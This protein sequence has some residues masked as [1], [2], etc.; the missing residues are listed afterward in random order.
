[1]EKGAFLTFVR[2]HK[3]TV[4]LSLAGVAAVGGTLGIWAALHRGGG[5]SA[6]TEYARNVVLSKGELNQSVLV[7][8]TVESAQVSSVTTTLPYKVKSVN[9][10]VGDMVK[11]GDIICVLDDGELRRE[12]ADKQ[13]AAGGEVKTLQE[14]RDKAYRQLAAARTARGTEQAAQDQLV[15]NAR[16]VLAGAETE[17]QRTA[18]IYTAAQNAYDTMAAAVAP[19]QIAYDQ[20]AAE[21]Q[22][23]YGAWVQSGGGAGTAP[24]Q[25]YQQMLQQERQCAQ[26][27]EDAKTL[28]DYE[29]YAQA[30]QAA[31]APYDQAAASRQQA[32]EAYDQALATRT[33]TLGEQD[34]G[35]A[36]L[37]AAAGTATSQLE[38]SA[39]G[40]ELEELQ[41][42]LEE[43]TLRAETDGKVTALAVNVGSVC[44]GDVATIQSTDQLIVSVK[45]PEYDIAKVTV[46][47]PVNITS[48]AAK[49]PVKGTLSRISPTAGTAGGNNGEGTNG[50]SGGDSGFSA[51]I[52]VHDPKELFIGSK[53]K[54]EIVVSQKKDVF[55]VPLD[56]L[57]TGKDGGDCVLLLQP[58]GKYKEVPV[59]VGAQND[60]DAEVSGP[61]ITEGAQVLANASWEELAGQAAGDLEKE[62]M[63]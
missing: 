47:M 5:E 33:R 1:M 57:K 52:T 36:E 21:R 54:A 44:K 25:H 10:K 19:A 29:R 56:A 26:A 38:S 37:E 4:A 58:D 31:K 35:I 46:G 17:V 48:D 28:Y 8:G 39:A 13:K 27:L 61:N 43:T 34:A 7:S 51:D 15:E 42:K 53:A 16:Q 55:T 32:Q 49:Q 45:I 20:A 60:F 6:G 12:L 2:Q 40:K 30:L 9:V 11:K 24:H 23:A 59:T 18:P 50:G 22:R 41:K 63:L 14:S 3:K 62:E